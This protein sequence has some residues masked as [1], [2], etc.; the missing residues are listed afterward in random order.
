MRRSRDAPLEAKAS[1]RL[2]HRPYLADVLD[3]LEAGCN[4]LPDDREGHLLRPARVQPRQH[5][6]APL[7]RDPRQRLPPHFV[8]IPLR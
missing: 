1:G 2:R 5:R 6:R 3:G 7:H 4:G 8:R